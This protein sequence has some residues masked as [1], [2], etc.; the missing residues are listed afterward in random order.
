MDI[1]LLDGLPFV[2]VSFS[3]NDKVIEIDRVLIDTGSY[4]TIISTDIMFELGME[5]LIDD[6]VRQIR[7]VGGAEFVITKTL[8][9]LSIDGRD[10][11]NVP[12]EVGT[13]DY[14]FKLNAIIGI[15]IL[16]QAGCTIDLPTMQLKAA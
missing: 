9:K 2:K 5:P 4:S 11:V 3:N 12:I 16:M 10:L 8:S 1:V 15:D 14:G 13:L 7:G 6:P